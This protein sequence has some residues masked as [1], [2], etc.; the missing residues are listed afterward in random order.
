MITRVVTR[1]SYGNALD[2]GLSMFVEFQKF[3]YPLVISISRRFH[4]PSDLH[5]L[6]SFI[7]LLFASKILSG[8]TSTLFLM[9]SYFIVAYCT[10]MIN[11]SSKLKSQFQFIFG[12]DSFPLKVHFRPAFYC[13]T[14][15]IVSAL[16]DGGMPAFTIT[17]FTKKFPILFLQALGML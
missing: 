9:T 15:R 7:S 8:L 10:F 1:S 17:I 2:Y 3:L 16:M 11:F 6:L 4:N 5:L 14:L 12:Q 13:R